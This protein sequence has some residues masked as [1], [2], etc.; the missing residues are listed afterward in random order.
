MPET[1]CVISIV[2]PVYNEAP[3]IAP[4]YERVTRVMEALGEPYELVFVNDGSTDDS[5]DRLLSL[6]GKDPQ[7]KVVD[8]SRNF[9]KEIALTAGLDYAS[10]EAV[11]PIDADLQ[12]P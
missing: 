3:N 9:G 7:V 2:V 8:L 12:D 11:I 4:F 10:G 6:A 5:L 1:R